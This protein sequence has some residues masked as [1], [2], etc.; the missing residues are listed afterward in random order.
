[1]QERPQIFGRQMTPWYRAYDGRAGTTIASGTAIG[2]Q[3]ANCRTGRLHFEQAEPLYYSASSARLLLRQQLFVVQQMREP[4]PDV[5]RFV[6]MPG[7]A[8]RAPAHRKRL[9]AEIR[10]DGEHGFVSD[11]VAD[12][13]RAA[14]LERLVGH[15]FAHSAGLVEAGMLD[16]ADAFS[17]EHLDWRIGQVGPDQ[18]YRLI[19]RLLR[20]R[21]QAV[22]QRQRVAL[23]FQK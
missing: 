22:M 5:A 4:F 14:A 2:V 16:L 21:R 1:M 13:H 6:E 18:G 7:H 3:R 23:V 9:T 15:Q 12:E 20:M 8:M 19:D 17:R 10:H 11:V